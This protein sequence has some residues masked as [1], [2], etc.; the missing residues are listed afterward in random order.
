MNKKEGHAMFLDGK[1]VYDKNAYFAEVNLRFN[2]SAHTK[3]Q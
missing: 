1:A 2:R 3:S